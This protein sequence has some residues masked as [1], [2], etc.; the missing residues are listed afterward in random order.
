MLTSAGNTTPGI[1]HIV[2]TRSSYRKVVPPVQL[3]F[4]RDRIYSITKSSL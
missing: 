3:A 1:L 2:Y 4:S